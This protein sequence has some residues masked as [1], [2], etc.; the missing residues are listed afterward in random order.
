MPVHLRQLKLEFKVRNGAESAD[1]GNGSNFFGEKR[2]LVG[3][4][5]TFFVKITTS[6]GAVLEDKVNIW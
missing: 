4:T 6:V 1:Y 5:P 3:G 2:N